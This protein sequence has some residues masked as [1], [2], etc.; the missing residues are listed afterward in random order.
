MGCNLEIMHSIPSW[1]V[2]FRIDWQVLLHILCNTIATNPP[3]C[4]HNQFHSNNPLHSSF[5]QSYAHPWHA[6]KLQYHTTMRGHQTSYPQIKSIPS[7]VC[8]AVHPPPML[9]EPTRQESIWVTSHKHEKSQL[10]LSRQLVVA[11]YCQVHS[12]KF[13]HQPHRNLEWDKKFLYRRASHHSKQT[14]TWRFECCNHLWL[15]QCRNFYVCM[16]HPA[17]ESQ[18]QN[19]WLM[20][21]TPI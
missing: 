13:G 16:P 10:P 19:C 2:I 6:Y 18:Q 14:N 7:R 20:A 4:L 5:G 12:S 3:L 15:L 8:R 17:C 9:D 21:T 1:F 11:G